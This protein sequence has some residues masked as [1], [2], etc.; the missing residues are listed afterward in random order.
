[1]KKILFSLLALFVSTTLSLCLVSC[2]D[3]DGGSSN[4]QNS[5]VGNYT[6][7][8]TMEDR[9]GKERSYT[10]TMSITST[11]FSLDITFDDDNS[12]T[13][14][15]SPYSQNGS[16]ITFYIENAEQ[17]YSF[18]VSADRKKMNILYIS[19][20]GIRLKTINATLNSNTGDNTSSLRV[21]EEN[22][23]GKWL[24]VS[25]ETKVRGLNTVV[26]APVEVR[27]Q[28]T[29][30]LNKDGSGYVYGNSDDQIDYFNWFVEKGTNTVKAHLGENY[31]FTHTLFD[32]VYLQDDIM[33]VDFASINPDVDY[34]EVE[35]AYAIFQRQK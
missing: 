33:K 16:T 35:Y 2:G 21:T 12:T 20:D 1:M 34:E 4:D 11:E 19:G 26:T 9:S 17:V 15:S 10:G 24:M 27:D 5:I 8:G 30:V 18:T 14:F 32:V 13:T 25:A 28:V 22:L 23:V 3:D 31:A 6:I 29:Y 7:S